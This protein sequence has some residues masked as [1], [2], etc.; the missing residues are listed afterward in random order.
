[1]RGKLS[2]GMGQPRSFSSAHLSTKL[3]RS[4]R[5]HPIASVIPYCCFRH[6]KNSQNHVTHCANRGVGKRSSGVGV[7]FNYKTS[8]A[9]DLLQMQPAETIG[10]TDNCN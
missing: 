2:L 8:L 1:M 5:A 6:S 4:A 7:L 10:A 9:A 3:S